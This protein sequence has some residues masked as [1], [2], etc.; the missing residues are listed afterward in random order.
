MCPSGGHLSAVI[1]DAE[2]SEHKQEQKSQTLISFGTQGNPG[3]A[4]VYLTPTVFSFSLTETGTRR[5]EK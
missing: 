4:M 1:S 2:I 3:A 5:E